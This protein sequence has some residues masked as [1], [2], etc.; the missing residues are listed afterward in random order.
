[1][2]DSSPEIDALLEAGA[3]DAERFVQESIAIDQAYRDG[4]LHEWLDAK[5]AAEMKAIGD[6]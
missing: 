5:L 2:A 3:T 1:M 6:G 4:K